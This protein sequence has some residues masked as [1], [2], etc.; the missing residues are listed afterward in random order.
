MDLSGLD[1]VRLYTKAQDGTSI[2]VTLIYRKTTTLT[3]RNPAILVAYG[4]YGVTLSPSFDPALLAWLEKGGVYAIAHVRG[5]GEFGLAWHMAGMRAQKANTIQDFIAAAQFL[6]SYGFTN[7][8]KLAAMGEGAG[9][10]PVAGAM[11]RRP[12]LFGAVVLRSPI[13]D[14]VRLE[15]TSNGP[16]NIPEFGSSTTA[17]GATMLRAISPL[18]QVKEGAVYPPVLITASP[19]E[20]SIALSQPGKLAAR[21]QA[22]TPVGPIGK[23][24]LMR[25]G[26]ERHDEDLAD[27]FSFVLWALDEK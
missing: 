16:A 21:L 1:E 13:T 24:V 5:G 10:I 27:I 12:D 15:F 7:P 9:A 4:S 25:V 17:Q 23:P 14:L 11:L 26:P 8:A 3:G 6:S 22:A 18:H 20:P 2:P 19:D